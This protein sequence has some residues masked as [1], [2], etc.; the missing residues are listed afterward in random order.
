MN[1]YCRIYPEN[2][3][4]AR[5]GENFGEMFFLRE[6]SIRM[7]NK[8]ST[9]DFLQLPQYSFFGDYQIIYELKS[10]CNFRTGDG[11]CVFMCV[12]KKVMRDLMELFP[13]TAKNLKI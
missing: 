10:I 11:P 7:Q 8:F 13:N 1:M 6:G 5:Y 4:V 12:R 9:V 2:T 3:A